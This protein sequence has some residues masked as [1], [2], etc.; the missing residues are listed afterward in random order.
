MNN[1]I[2]SHIPKNRQSSTLTATFISSVHFVEA[3]P[4]YK[5]RCRR[6]VAKAVHDRFKKGDMA[7]FV[8]VWKD[9]LG[10]GTHG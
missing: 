8:T 2:Q 1:D 5:V 10:G 3:D 6:G 9:I 4:L 7:T